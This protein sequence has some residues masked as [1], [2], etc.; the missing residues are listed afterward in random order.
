MQTSLPIKTKDVELVRKTQGIGAQ[1]V[2]A[3]ANISANKPMSKQQKQINRDEDILKLM[4]AKRGHPG[5]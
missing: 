3:V 4:D 5:S 2:I 1:W